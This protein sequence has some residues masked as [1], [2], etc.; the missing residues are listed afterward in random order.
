MNLTDLRK[1]IDT[2]DDDICKLFQ[3]RMEVVDAVGE[4]KRAHNEPVNNGMRERDILTRISKSLPP[5]LE[6]F[7]RSLYRSIFDISN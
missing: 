6:D 5:H 3:K 4:Y 1:K 7:G 2:I